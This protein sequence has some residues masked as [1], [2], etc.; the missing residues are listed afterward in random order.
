MVCFE[1]IIA[2]LSVL[3]LAEPVELLLIS[4]FVWRYFEINFLFACLLR[5]ISVNRSFLSSNALDFG[6]CEIWRIPSSFSFQTTST[7]LSKIDPPTTNDKMSCSSEDCD[8]D[9]ETDRLLGAQRADERP[10][11]DDKVGISHLRTRTHRVH[12]KLA[13][14][15]IPSFLLTLYRSSQSKRRPIQ[16][17]VGI[18]SLFA[19][20]CP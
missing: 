10:Y 8:T 1:L 13:I 16:M 9:Q 15:L 5:S 14:E 19:H 7:T 20:G 11:F 18:K 2:F 17:M 3:E 6:I 12:V 4:I